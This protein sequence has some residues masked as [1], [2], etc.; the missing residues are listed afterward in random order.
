M[1]IVALEEPEMTSLL[2]SG[3][4][5]TMKDSAPSMMASPITVTDWHTVESIIA[6]L[7]KV[8]RTFRNGWKSFSSEG[9]QSIIR[10]EVK[11]FSDAKNI[12]SHNVFSLGLSFL[13]LK[14]LSISF[15][16]YFCYNIFIH[17]SAILSALYIF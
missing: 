4:T 9:G 1:V 11:I 12:A 6:V 5:A 7:E 17:H 15:F 13:S 8:R 16:I 3:V 2:F 14:L 10:R